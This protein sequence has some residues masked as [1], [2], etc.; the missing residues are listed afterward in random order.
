MKRSIWLTLTLTLVLFNVDL[1]RGQEITE[2]APVER[3]H[4]TRAEKPKD[5]ASAI[6]LLKDAIES[7]KTV[8]C[9]TVCSEMIP[10][11]K[12]GKL[13]HDGT[14]LMEE[15]MWRWDAQSSQMSAKGVAILSHPNGDEYGYREFWGAFDGDKVRTFCEP[16]LKGQIVPP[17]TQMGTHFSMS[18]LLGMYVGSGYPI[19]GICNF[20]EGGT[21]DYDDDD[22]DAILLKSPLP[23]PERRCPYQVLVWLDASKGFLA[24]KFEIMVPDIGVTHYRMEI[25]EFLQA[26]DNTWVPVKG[27]WS[28][29]ST[30]QVIPAGYTNEQVNS[31]SLEEFQKLGVTYR[32]KASG[33]PYF[34]T[35]DP[36]SLRVNEPIDATH[37]TIDFPV[38]AVIFDAFK[39]NAFKVT[40]TGPV[41]IEPNAARSSRR[42]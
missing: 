34:V 16:T 33:S 40:A 41:Y 13:L 42:R 18:T 30:E 14:T 10:V 2:A 25:L 1:I 36:D 15:F 5:A 11:K 6:S 27:K 21:L 31:L 28:R 3:Q 9:K 19:E 26:P 7:I 37:F 32:G 17:G 20:L 24:K 12:G 8:Q 39:D 23:T 29:W 22:P 38:G 4:D 35:I